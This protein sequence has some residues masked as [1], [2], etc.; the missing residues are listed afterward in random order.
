[1]SSEVPV[2]ATYT[3]LTL[4]GDISDHDASYFFA[5]N[6]DRD[7]GKEAAELLNQW[8][9]EKKIKVLPKTHARKKQGMSRLEFQTDDVNLIQDLREVGSGLKVK[10][11]AV[12]ATLGEPLTFVRTF[13][14]AP[15]E[16]TISSKQRDSDS[17]YYANNSGMIFSGPRKP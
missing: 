7:R 13:A 17:S 12:G 1:M 5:G 10:F 3:N 8:L 9:L 2:L 4:C 16:K 6:A 14:P 11:V 15:K